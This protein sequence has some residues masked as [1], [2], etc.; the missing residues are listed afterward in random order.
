MREQLVDLQRERQESRDHRI[1][2]RTLLGLAS[3]VALLVV[4]GAVS[5]R[6]TARETAARV[7]ALEAR[8]AA[9]ELSATRR[10]TDDRATSAA[11]VRLQA[12]METL[13]S[14]IARRLDAIDQRLTPSS[15]R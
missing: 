15:H 12:T 10:D 13:Q 14:T 6:D 4:L 7:V 8:V 11:I 2:V 1:Y 3:A 5:V 9:Q